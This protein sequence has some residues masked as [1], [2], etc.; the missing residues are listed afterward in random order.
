MTTVT[1]WAMTNDKRL[2]LSEFGVCNDD[3]NGQIAISNLLEYLNNNNVWIGWTLWNLDSKDCSY[4]VTKGSYTV[5][6]PAMAW[7][8]PYLTPNIVNT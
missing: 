5:D 4:L 2:F 3:P 7:Y 6:G 8:T 1:K